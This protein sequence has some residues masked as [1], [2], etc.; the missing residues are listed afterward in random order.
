M[1]AHSTLLAAS[2]VA[3]M[4]VSTGVEAAEPNAPSRPFTRS[5]AKSPHL[6]SAQLDH[7]SDCSL[8]LWYDPR[9]SRLLGRGID[10]AVPRNA[11]LSV[12][13]RYATIAVTAVL[14]GLSVDQVFVPAFPLQTANQ[15]EQNSLHLRANIEAARASLSAAWS[16]EFVKG[17]PEGPAP[18]EKEV[19]YFSSSPR[20]RP[21][22]HAPS[23]DAAHTSVHCALRHDHHVK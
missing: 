11:V 9:R 5:V 1:H 18:N 2:I 21:Y 7:F 22:L 19:A 23:P 4:F 13:E 20:F 6:T 10:V 3:Q 14:H 16:I 15:A 8:R 17:T 12:N